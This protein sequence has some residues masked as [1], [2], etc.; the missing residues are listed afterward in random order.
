MGWRMWRCVRNYCINYQKLKY[1][2]QITNSLFCQ[3]WINLVILHTYLLILL[4]NTKY[5]QLGTY[6]TITNDSNR[7]YDLKVN[8][9][10]KN[11]VQLHI[12]N[13]LTIISKIKY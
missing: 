2:T 12:C 1:Q 10:K 4:D 13:K 3:I 8:H 5:I 9:N 7:E 11:I 6:L